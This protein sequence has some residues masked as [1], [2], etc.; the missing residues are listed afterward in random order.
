MEVVVLTQPLGGTATRCMVACQ[1]F[2]HL[3]RP[4]TC[5][6]AGMG[7]RMQGD[8]EASAGG[9]QVPQTGFAEPTWASLPPPWKSFRASPRYDWM[10]KQHEGCLKKADD[11]GGCRQEGADLGVGASGRGREAPTGASLRKLGS[12]D[13]RLLVTRN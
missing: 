7:P 6:C 5:G 11:T 8:E 12:A 4:G 13:S 9:R 1:D 3:L 2:L 10:I